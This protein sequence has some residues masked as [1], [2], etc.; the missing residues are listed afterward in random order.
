MGKREKEDGSQHIT[1][2]SYYEVMK[3]SR[4]SILVIENVPEYQESLVQRELGGE[5]KLVSVRVDPRILGLACCRTRV[6]MVCWKWREVRW[7]GPCTLDSCLRILS[8]RVTMN[9]SDYFW[10]S[11]P[12]VRLTPSAVP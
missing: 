1:H 4:N 3:K 11:L 2:K 10:K 5:W 12:K 6:F 7:V 9:I 8:A